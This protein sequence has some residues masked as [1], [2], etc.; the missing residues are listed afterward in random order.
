VLVTN[1]IY[2][3]GGR[4]TPDGSSSN[5]IVVTNAITVRSVNGPGVTAIVGQGPLGDNA[6]RCA[7]L[8]PGAI[9]SGFTLSNGHTRIS[10]LD[11]DRHGGGVYASK[12][13]IANCTIVRNAAR[14]EGGGIYGGTANNCTI[15]ANKAD[16]GAGACEAALNACLISGNEAVWE[17]GGTY[18]TT[19]HSC[20]VVGNAAD[21]GGGT[22]RSK[23]R[24][25]IVYY[26]SAPSD[27]NWYSGSYAFTCTTPCPHGKG[28]IA[29]DPQL[30]SAYRLG[31]NSPC[32]GAGDFAAV[33]ETD[34]D[35]EAWMNPPCMGCDQVME[36]AWTGDLIVAIVAPRTNPAV[37]S[38]AEFTANVQGKVHRSEWNFGDEFAVT[39]RPFVTHAWMAPGNYKVTLTAWNETHPAGKSVTA[40]VCVTNQPARP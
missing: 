40:T 6:V 7:Y 16:Y 18:N 23:A 5:R 22:Y 38:A 24:N 29:D 32:I 9:L 1:G 12:A 34:I 13:L 26:N 31:A 19:L 3:A 37:G 4:I 39:N 35:G 14:V 10:N 20:T 11:L 17:G 25:S 27:P 8:A 33:P 21:Y 15:S 2:A 28:N 36:G 30:A